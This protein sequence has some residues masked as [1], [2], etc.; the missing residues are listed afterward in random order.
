M[1]APQDKLGRPT[2]SDDAG[3][4]IR[5]ARI[6]RGM[7]QAQLG[8]AVGYSPSAISRLERGRLRA[9]DVD[10]LRS[11]ATALQIAPELLGVSGHTPAAVD[12]SLGR[13]S[14]NDGGAV[15]RRRF[16]LGATGVAGTLLGADTFA[17]P[18]HGA[19]TQALAR[20]EAACLG[21]SWA[22]D[23]VD[24]DTTRRW[25]DQAR[26]AFSNGDYIGVTNRL[27]D[28]LAVASALTADDAARPESY[29]VLAHAYALVTETLIKIGGSAI[30]P[31]TADRAVTMAR[32]SESPIAFS[33]AA[34]QLATVL[35][36][37]G[38]P[39]SALRLATEATDVL[40]ARGLTSLTARA[41]YA[42]SLCT[43]AYIAATDGRR[44]MALDMVHEARQVSDR[45][46][47]ASDQ[48][49]AAGVNVYAI[50][51]HYALGEAGA[52]VATAAR[53][54][55]GQLP[56]AERRARYWCDT[57]RAWHQFGDP[58]RTYRALVAAFAEAPAEVRDRASMRMLVA[59]LLRYDGR[60]PGVRRF[61]EK[62]HA[63]A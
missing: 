16:L 53:V 59:G 55:P 37:S 43:T 33:V 38:R 13:L 22:P 21:P 7:T 17:E 14:P 52:A 19:T 32:L 35:R 36:H 45:L 3:S 25:F 49:S 26:R 48:F 30:A 18:R 1:N 28:V 58:R 40:R 63:L 50:G 15:Q 61:A 31:I 46:D 5:A 44:E 56:T 24:L 60:L 27:V 34:R 12:A 54:H 6:A 2:G 20:L 39:E 29:V 9:G 41:F 57:A 42:R 11:L 4:V 23:G 8:R 51:V 47:Q 10:V 62:V